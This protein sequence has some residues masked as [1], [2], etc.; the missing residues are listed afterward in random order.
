LATHDPMTGIYNRRKFFELGTTLFENSSELFVVMFDIDKFKNINDIYGHPVGDEV[1]KA[2]T[3][4]ISS[5]KQQGSIFGRLGGEEF[6]MIC[7]EK[8]HDL[9]AQ[10]ME[11]IRNTI[12][13][14]DI[15][16]DKN[17]TVNFTISS[18]IAKK[19]TDTKKLDYLLKAADD[20]LYEAKNTGRN[21][22][23]FRV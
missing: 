5:L 19:N 10:G 1:I 15:I 13:L 7:V 18:G 22:V 14:L 16:T 4:T 20:A 6:A 21:K 11:K 8:N 9:I 12:E 3:H 17:E 2:V 23:I